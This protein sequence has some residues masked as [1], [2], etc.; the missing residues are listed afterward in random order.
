MIVLINNFDYRKIDNYRQVK[1]SN[2][3]DY[4]YFDKKCNSWV[5]IDPNIN[6][7]TFFRLENALRFIRTIRRGE[8]KMSK[9]IFDIAKYNLESIEQLNKRS[10]I[11]VG[12]ENFNSIKKALELGKLYKDLANTIYELLLE[13]N[14][15][16]INIELMFKID[17]LKEQIKVLENE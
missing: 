11:K 6:T 2:K 8:P 1:L 15:R 7:F 16:K 5:V 9:N 12:K 4:L 17:R 14:N 13:V 3:I 10:N